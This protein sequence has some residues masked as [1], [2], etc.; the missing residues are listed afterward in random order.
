MGSEGA[1]AW[2]KAKPPQGERKAVEL[3]NGPGRERGYSRP[4]FPGDLTPG[5]LAAVLVCSGSALMQENGGPGPEPQPEAGGLVVR[6]MSKSSALS[7]P[8]LGDCLASL[9][10]LHEALL[11]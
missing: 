8:L 9:L 1:S 2:Q 10:L 5:R 6:R 7:S 4:G 3:G 11:D